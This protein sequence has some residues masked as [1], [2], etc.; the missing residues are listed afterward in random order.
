MY[1]MTR[2][3]AADT[4]LAYHRLVEDVR[5]VHAYLLSTMPLGTVLEIMRPVERV[6]LDS[7]LSETAQPPVGTDATGSHLVTRDSQPPA[8][9]AVL[10]RIQDAWDRESLHDLAAIA[11]ELLS[12]R[13]DG[14]SKAPEGWKLVPVE[15][16]AAYMAVASK[17]A[18]QV[19]APATEI[20]A[21][22]WEMVVTA[23][24]YPFDYEGAKIAMLAAAPSSGDE[25][26]K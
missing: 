23:H 19:I 14:G 2:E 18:A 12:I 4:A 26:S 24:P 6:L 13:A 22:F 3:E 8:R 7:A 25:H 1:G 15:P 16:T 9:E 20:A 10:V 17:Y 5:R 21:T 11:R